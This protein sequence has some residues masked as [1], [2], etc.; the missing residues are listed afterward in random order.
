VR[1]AIVGFADAVVEAATEGGEVAELADQLAG[2]GQLV[3]DS[4]DLRVALSDP[5]VPAPSRRGLLTDLLSGR[6]RPEMLSLLAYVAE[7]DRATEFSEDLAWLETRAAAARDRLVP[8]E[9]P[10]GR[11]TAQERLAGYATAVLEG[12]ERG[13]LDEIEDELFR[14]MQTVAGSDRL[15]AALTDRDVSVDARQGLVRDLL[16]GRAT[17]ATVRLAAY[18]TRVGRARDYLALLSTAVDR[19]AEERGRRVADVRAAAELNEEARRRLAEALGRLT[20]RQVELRV[21]T[22]PSL[23]GGFVATV[24]DTVVDGSTRHRLDQL[25]DRLLLPEAT[26]NQPRENR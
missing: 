3:A 4:P 2:F 5:E 10:Q 25:K 19:V 17:R 18:A 13:Q 11:V 9:G 14:F 22:D 15:Q 23:L 16:S 1:D 7:V 8:V 24:G 26:I 6:V 21:Q 12:V 20:G